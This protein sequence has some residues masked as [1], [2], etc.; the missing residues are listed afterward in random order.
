[1]DYYIGVWKK[2]RI[3]AG[4]ARRKEYW[5][6]TLWNS[7]IVIVLS[8]ISAILA[9]FVDVGTNSSYGLFFFLLPVLYAL[10]VLEPGITVAVRRLH[11]TNRSGWW[12]LINLVP[13]IGGI[14]FLVFMC[15]D[16]QPGDNQYGPNPKGIAAAPTVIPPTVTTPPTTS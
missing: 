11:D 1:M 10:A 5:M 15:L 13:Y 7:I 16:S 9:I 6:F 12:F 4:R 3:L 14:I 2:Y 8:A